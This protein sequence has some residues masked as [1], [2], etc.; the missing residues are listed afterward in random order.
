MIGGFLDIETVEMG[1]DMDIGYVW[2]E[3]I[4]RARSACLVGFGYGY[5]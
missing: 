5:R 3:A 1:M 4:W 2:R